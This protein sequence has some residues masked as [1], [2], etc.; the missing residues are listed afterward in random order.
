[1]MGGGIKVYAGENG[2]LKKKIVIQIMVKWYKFLINGKI[3][4][5]NKYL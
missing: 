4:F 3:N 5:K 1:M 2:M